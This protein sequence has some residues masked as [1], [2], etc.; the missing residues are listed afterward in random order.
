VPKKAAKQGVL[1]PEGCFS[2]VSND[3]CNQL[4]GIENGRIGK[5]IAE[6]FGEAVLR[7]SNGVYHDPAFN[8]EIQ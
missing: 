2:T 5:P 8:F 7:N 1:T 4:Q 3:L 6:P